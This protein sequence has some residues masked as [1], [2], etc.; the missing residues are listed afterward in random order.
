MAARAA[1]VFVQVL[2]ASV[3]RLLELEQ[4]LQK[5]AEALSRL[6][7]ELIGAELYASS[8]RSGSGQSGS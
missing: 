8:R 1:S 3:F 2:N 6:G 7:A 5:Y 4:P